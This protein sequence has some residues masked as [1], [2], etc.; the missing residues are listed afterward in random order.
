MEKY[1]ERASLSCNRTS[2]SSKTTEALALSPASAP[3]RNS[4]HKNSQSLTT[5][6]LIMAVQQNAQKISEYIDLILTSIG[7]RIDWNNFYFLRQTIKRRVFLSKND[8]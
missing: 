4:Y 5:N 2:L 6:Q 7:R 1:K 3:K 8:E